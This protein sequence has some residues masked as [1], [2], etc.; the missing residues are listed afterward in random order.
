MVMLFQITPI[1]VFDVAGEIAR[2]PCGSSLA[3]VLAQTSVLG[4]TPEQ[5]IDAS[6]FDGFVPFSEAT[7]GATPGGGT[8]SGSLF[9]P[10]LDPVSFFHGQPVSGSGVNPGAIL[11]QGISSVALPPV[12]PGD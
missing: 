5:A 3:E 4:L 11:P 9:T 10:V 8:G 12:A 6:T 7:M 2:S 1:S